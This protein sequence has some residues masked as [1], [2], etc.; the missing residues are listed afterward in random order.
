ME[1]QGIS[2]EWAALPPHIHDASI[3][4]LDLKTVYPDKHFSWFSVVCAGRCQVNTQ[5]RS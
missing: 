5:I 1:K 3:S 4:V 2:V